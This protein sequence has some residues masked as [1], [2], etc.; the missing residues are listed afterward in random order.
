MS[1]FRKT[2][3][4]L[5]NKPADFTWNEAVRIF[6]HLGYDLDDSG[7]GADFSFINKEKGEYFAMPKPHTK[8]GKPA[9]K[10]HYIKEMIKHLKDHNYI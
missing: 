5:L 6:K 8:G 4:R 1:K 2:L 7:G 3:D 10:S 9:I